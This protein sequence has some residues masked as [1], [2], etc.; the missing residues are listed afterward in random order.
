MAKKQRE[1]LPGA[2]KGDT[3][4]DVRR[5]PQQLQ[6]D[7]PAAGT[8]MGANPPVQFIAAALSGLLAHPQTLPIGMQSED[9]QN[10][11][12]LQALRLAKRMETIRQED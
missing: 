11:L 1:N 9:Y 10:H 7:I 3:W 8:A 12:C 6:P 4:R 2:E 5:Q